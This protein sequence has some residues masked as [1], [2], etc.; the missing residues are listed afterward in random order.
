M[1]AGDGGA[2]LGPYSEPG[3]VRMSTDSATSN[4]WLSAQLTMLAAS[5]VASGHIRQSPPLARLNAAS[6]LVPVLGTGSASMYPASRPGPPPTTGSAVTSPAIN[7]PPSAV[8]SSA[9]RVAVACNPRGHWKPPGGCS[10]GSFAEPAG[11]PASETSFSGACDIGSILTG[12]AKWRDKSCRCS[13]LGLSWW[14]AL[15]SDRGL[16]LIGA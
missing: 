14:G 11:G 9:R 1:R 7:K 2:A 15:P 5:G 8:S 13:V 4:L 12:P 16:K 3:K 10:A 6:L